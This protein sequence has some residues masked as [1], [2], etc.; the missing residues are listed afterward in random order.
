M[1][2]QLLI[3]VPLVDFISLLSEISELLEKC[4]WNPTIGRMESFAIENIIRSK[5]QDIRFAI[6]S[7][8]GVCNANE[9]KDKNPM[10]FEYF[11]KI[12]GKVIWIIHD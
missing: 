4:G 11:T 9:L 1:S 7:Y 6:F 8:F 3:N 5:S 12:F 10:A 2:E